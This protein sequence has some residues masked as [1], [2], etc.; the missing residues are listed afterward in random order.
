MHLAQRGKLLNKIKEELLPIVKSDDPKNSPEEFK[1]ILSLLN[2]A[3]RADADWEQF[4]VH[5]DHV[6]SN[7]LS[8][9][10]ERVPTLSANDLKLCAYLKM[11]LS[12][13]EMAQLMSV[14]IRAVEVSRYRLRKKLDV[15][16][17]TN[18]FNYLMAIT[19]E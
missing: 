17:D 16:S 19:A 10:K 14:T 6:H 13:K 5:F 2:D 4:S 15:S 11:N 18:L 8:K 9:L 7:F 3:E 1:K 12:S